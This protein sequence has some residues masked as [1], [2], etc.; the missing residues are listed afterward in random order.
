MDGKNGKR[1]GVRKRKVV[2][3]TYL[4]QNTWQ[5]HKRP[6]VPEEEENYDSSRQ[7]DIPQVHDND[8]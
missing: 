3:K 5:R 4:E 6:L 2:T 8:I 7:V 1:S